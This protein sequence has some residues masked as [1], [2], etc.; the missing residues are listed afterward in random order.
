M[1][2]FHDQHGVTPHDD[3]VN[4]SFSTLFNIRNPNRF[5]DMP[6]VLLPSSAADFGKPLFSQFACTVDLI[7]RVFPSSF[8]PPSP[9]LREFHEVT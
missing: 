8:S 9:S 3:E 6:T 4:F 2:L 1:L 7:G 5:K